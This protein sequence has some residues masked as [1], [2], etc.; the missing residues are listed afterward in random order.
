M[1]R[2]PSRRAEG[3][4]QRPSDGTSGAYQPRWHP[5]KLSGRTEDGPWERPDFGGLDIEAV[6]DLMD[7]WKESEYLSS[8]A[9][10]RLD[11]TQ[12]DTEDFRRIQDTRDKYLERAFISLKERTKVH[13]SCARG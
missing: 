5:K 9:K 1:M 12:D 6:K 11:R 8:S 7:I 13:L 2:A 3:K 10:K 4:R